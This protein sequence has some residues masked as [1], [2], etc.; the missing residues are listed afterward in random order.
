MTVAYQKRPICGA[1]GTK[2]LHCTPM[3]RSFLLDRCV[4]D[5]TQASA[6]SAV[7]LTANFYIIPYNKGG[8]WISWQFE[9]CTKLTK[10]LES[11]IA[12]CIQSPRLPAWCQAGDFFPSR[13]RQLLISI[14]CPG[15]AVAAV[16]LVASQL[17]PSGEAPNHGSAGCTNRPT[18]S[19][20]SPCGVSRGPKKCP[21][22]LVSLS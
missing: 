22:K 7:Q 5:I 19:T 21:T 12:S 17:T 8:T 9:F 20:C 13:L 4:C 1:I 16:A 14:K 10:I 6:A 3:F 15:P 11:H 2:C 18:C